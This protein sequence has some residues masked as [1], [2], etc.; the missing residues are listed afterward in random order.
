MTSLEVSTLQNG[1]DFIDGVA[2][3]RELGD[4]FSIVNPWFKKYIQPGHLVEVRIDSPRFSMHPDAPVE[5]TCEHC[6]EPA[7]KP[8]LCHEHPQ[9][10]LPVPRQDVP[11][12][13]WG[14][15]FWIVVEDRN[16]KRLT[17]SI[18]NELYETRL[19]GLSY[20]DQ[21]TIDLAHVLALH[22][23]HNEAMLFSMSPED[24]HE[25]RTWL[26]ENGWE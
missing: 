20:Q 16:E 10:L 7:T 4:R 9:S 5:C 3:H 1:Y 17:G 26:V 13:G 6:T 11:S 14:E 15:Q 12:K 22:P 23:S 8:I 18:D 2:M 24:L 25:F 21:I 19:H